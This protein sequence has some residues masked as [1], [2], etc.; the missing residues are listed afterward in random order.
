MRIFPILAVVY[1]ASSVAQAAFTI[2]LD[3]VFSGYNPVGSTPYLSAT[4]TGGQAAANCGGS[5]ANGCVQVTL[6]NNLAS[7]QFVSEWDFNIRNISALT[8]LAFYDSSGL[9]TDSVGQPVVGDT[10]YQNLVAPAGKKTQ[11][12]AYKADGDG[13]HDWGFL[14][15][16]DGASRFFAGSKTFYLSGV[17]AV[18][19]EAD[20]NSLGTDS[21][22]GQYRSAAHIQG[23]P[24]TPTCSGWVGDSGGSPGGAS[25]G[26][27]SAVPEPLYSGL[28]LTGTLIAFAYLARRRLL[29]GA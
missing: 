28:A 25:S 20:F 9:I 23:I 6:T 16:T 29:M 15:P 7:G 21:G 18:I 10:T 17:G 5:N 14:F 13:Y 22:N 24:G 1:C 27:C 11:Y 8:A 12:D 4:F 2:D 26:S 19:A 3:H